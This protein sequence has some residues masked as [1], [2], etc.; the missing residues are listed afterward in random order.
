M[1]SKPLVSVITI[2]LDAERFLE[3]AIESVFAQIYDNWEL[4]LV[5]DSSV[6]RSTDIALRY[7]EQHP[8]KVR[9]C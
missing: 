5:D 6:D 8:D 7:A 9:A 4:V 3:E 2:F 1:T